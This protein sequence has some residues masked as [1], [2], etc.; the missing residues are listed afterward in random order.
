[1]EEVVSQL[2]TLI[3]LGKAS[4]IEPFRT[5]SKT[6]EEEWM[7]DRT[8]LEFNNT[9]KYLMYAVTGSQQDIE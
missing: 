1:M 3:E 9:L 5:A 4:T 7:D 2:M 8:N 6:M